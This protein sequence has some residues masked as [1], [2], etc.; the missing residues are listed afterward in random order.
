MAGVYEEF[1]QTLAAL[2]AKYAGR[3]EREMERLCLLALEREQLVAT[4]YRETLIATRLRSLRIEDD[5]QV[6]LRQALLWVWKDE[7]MH[8]IYI[9]GALRKVGRFF[10]RVQV[11]VQ[12]FSGALGGWAGSV[13]QHVRWR[14]A[15]LA[16]GGATLIGWLGRLTGKVPRAVR[17]SLDYQS[18]REFCRFNVDAERTAAACWAR[19]VELGEGAHRLPPHLV[20]EFRRIKVDE[21]CH[22]RI[23]E[24][25]AEVFDADDHLVAGITADELARR[26]GAVG[27]AFLPHARRRVPAAARSRP[28]FGGRVSVGRGA[29]GDKRVVLRRVVDEAG[30]RELVTARRNELGRPLAVAVK[31]TFMLGYSRRDRSTITDPELVDE[32]ARHLRELGADRVDVVEGR[33]IYDWYYGGRTVAEVARYFGLV[34]DQYRI[35]DLSDEQVPHDYDRGMAQH[36]IGRTWKDA[37]LRISFGKLRSHPIEVVSLTMG[38]LENIGARCDQFLFAERQAQRETAVMTMIGDF[39]PD[40]A[41]LDGYDSAPDG[42]LGVMGCARP[43]V[44]RRIYAGRDALAVDTVAARHIGLGDPLRSLMLRAAH[45]WFGVVGPVPIE[46]VGV[47]TPIAGWRGPYDSDWSTLLSLFA[48]PVYVHGSGRGKLF[49]PEMDEV[50]F[51]PLAKAGRSLRW[52]RRAMQRCLGLRLP[53]K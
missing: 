9:R 45:H 15:P 32:L 14:E 53:S 16:R 10:L 42:I 39:P 41:I 30:L 4:A 6:L 8:T 40:F 44:P 28:G 50:A 36:T 29:E 35:V 47:D 43:K 46:V 25:L 3:P 27:E 12:Q 18:F 23:F 51:P 13:R 20:A 7:E 22:R 34:S 1:E 24:I 49:V 17:R 52:G 5:V 11:V 2:K 48:Y 21:D 38:N 19:L 31:P 26:I 37:D 33:N